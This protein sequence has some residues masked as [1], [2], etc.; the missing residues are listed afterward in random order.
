QGSLTA[1]DNAK[2]VARVYGYKGKELQ[3]KVKFVED[4]AEI[5]KFFDEPM[6]TYSSG[7]SARIAF[8]LSMA[9]DFDYYLIDE[10]GAVGD[11]AFR[12]K[13]VKLYRERLSKSKVIMVSHNVA[14]IKEWCDKIIYMKNGQITVYDD[15]D[16][17]I[18]VYQGKV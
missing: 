13:S 18:A 2:F 11:P 1:R 7:M 15:V 9:F 17:G 5:G 10:A 16:E 6:K 3:E 4:F 12:E 8:G 14:E